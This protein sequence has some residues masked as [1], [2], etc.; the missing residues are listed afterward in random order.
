MAQYSQEHIKYLWQ[1]YVDNKATWEEL[2]SLLRHISDNR[3]GEYDVNF[4]ETY[5]SEMQ[6]DDTGD[7]ALFA[8]N[9]KRIFQL[10]AEKGLT[11]D[12]HTGQARLVR[13]TP[14][15]RKTWFRYAAAAVLVFGIGY[16]FYTPA[17]KSSNDFTTAEP[18]SEQK[19]VL[20][21]SDRA[22][23][24]LSDGRKIELDPDKQATIADGKLAI[25]DDNGMLTYGKS[26]VVVFNTMSTPKGGQYRLMLPDGTRVWLNAASSITYPTSFPGN[27]RIV[28]VT[29]EAYFEVAKDVSKP[30][31]VITNEKT[32][33]E[34]LGTHFNVNAYTDSDLFKTSLLEGSVRINQNILVPGQAY[35]N[36]E[37]VK[38]DLDQDI[39]WKNGVF[40]FH[41]VELKEVMRQLARWYD[42]EVV[43]Q[44]DIP[45]T[46]FFGEMGRD[47]TLSNVLKGLEGSGITFR[48]EEG[49]KIIVKR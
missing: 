34:V 49:R 29:G 25:N 18:V 46:R 13:K 35:L 10:Q 42:M 14:F 17:Q 16:Y 2:N 20:P 12:H 3:D 4:L 32:E 40:N 6:P 31:K 9:L 41:K 1:R 39:A 36:G 21:G 38:T 19:D 15:F 48:I 8:E 37:I 5:L 44:G 24:T 30:F 33:I 7:K 43:Y 45:K 11:E 23:L 28:S 47:L 22:I 26:D 27:S